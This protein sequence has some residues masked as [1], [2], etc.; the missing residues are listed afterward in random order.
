MGDASPQQI[1]RARRF[2]EQ[3]RVEGRLFKVRI[4]D[5]PVG[6]VDGLPHPPVLVEVRAYSSRIGETSVEKG[7]RESGYCDQGGISEDL[8]SEA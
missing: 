5:L 3:R 2:P 4:A 6:E 7:N 1:L 8:G